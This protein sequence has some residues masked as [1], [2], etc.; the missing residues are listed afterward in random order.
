MPLNALIYSVVIPSATVW[1]SFA[2]IL[3]NVC[4]TVAKPYTSLCVWPHDM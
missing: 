3:A 4:H 1:Q 2:T